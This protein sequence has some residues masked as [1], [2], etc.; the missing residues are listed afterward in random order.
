MTLKMSKEDTDMKNNN[1]ETKQLE[2]IEAIRG[3]WSKF[4]RLLMAIYLAYVIVMAIVS[5]AVQ[6]PNLCDKIRDYY[7]SV[8]KYLTDCCKKVVKGVTAFLSNFGH[9]N[10][11][12]ADLEDG[13][14]SRPIDENDVPED[15]RRR[16]E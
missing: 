9:C 13:F 14:V 3:G 5:I 7:K 10:V 12:M 2:T 15:I 11:T 8:G 6:L 16:A 1:V 4:M